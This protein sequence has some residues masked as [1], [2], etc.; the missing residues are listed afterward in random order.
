MEP[1]EKFWLQPPSSNTC[2]MQSR[3]EKKSLFANRDEPNDQQFL[4]QLIRD[5]VENFGK[6]SEEGFK[7]DPNE[8]SNEDSDQ[9]LDEAAHL[10]DLQ[11]D[12]KE[13]EALEKELRTNHFQNT[14]LQGMMD[15][16]TK[17][18]DVVTDEQIEIAEE[19]EDYVPTE[20]KYKRLNKRMVK[21]ER[22]IVDDPILESIDEDIKD[23][24]VG[25]ANSDELPL[26]DEAGE[27]PAPYRNRSTKQ[28]LSVLDQQMAELGLDDATDDSDASDFSDLDE[29][30][31]FEIAGVNIKE[32]MASEKLNPDAPSTNV[33]S[34]KQA[35][36]EK[37]DRLYRIP[38][39]RLLRED[40][41]VQNGESDEDYDDGDLVEIPQSNSESEDENPDSGDFFSDIPV[42]EETQHL[43][44][45]ETVVDDLKE[46]SVIDIESQKG[47]E[48]F[49]DKL[50][51]LRDKHKAWMKKGKKF[52]KETELMQLFQQY[53]S[54]KLKFKN[55]SP[56]E[57]QQL[58]DRFEEFSLNQGEG[59]GEGEFDQFSGELDQFQGEGEGEG[60]FEDEENS[61]SSSSSD[62]DAEI[63]LETDVGS[64][65]TNGTA[66]RSGSRSVSASTNG[67]ASPSGNGSTS[68]DASSSRS[69]SRST[70]HA[71]PAA[72]AIIKMVM[73]P[74]ESKVVDPPLNPDGPI[75]LPL[76]PSSHGHMEQ[77]VDYDGNDRIR[78]DRNVSATPKIRIV[79]MDDEQNYHGD[80]AQ[81]ADDV[82]HEKWENADDADVADE[83]DE[84][85]GFDMEEEELRFRGE[86][87]EEGYVMTPEEREQFL[88]DQA[89]VDEIN[90]KSAAFAN[91]PM[92]EKLTPEEWMRYEELNIRS[93]MERIIKAT[94]ATD[95]YGSNPENA[96]PHFWEMVKHK[97]V[98]MET[99]QREFVKYPKM[100]QR[101]SGVRKIDDLFKAGA[102]KLEGP[103]EQTVF[104]KESHE[105]TTLDFREHGGSYF[106]LGQN[107]DR[108][109]YFP[110]GLAGED[111]FLR[112]EFWPSDLRVHV[113]PLAS[114]IIRRID[115][116]EKKQ[117]PNTAIFGSRWTR[118]IWQIWNC[119]FN[120]GMGSSQRLHLHV[121]S[122]WE[123]MGFS[124]LW[125][126]R[127]Y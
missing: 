106:E 74:D 61:S 48:D 66:S 98:F 89:R 44:P 6:N 85:H 76:D 110:E 15:Q 38:R 31:D 93:Q 71:D 62:S 77:G 123:E 12:P 14:E 95:R 5:S 25:D 109:K 35:Y 59:E 72:D 122:R 9:D 50:E 82:A 20:K 70:H 19:M 16:M 92:W 27:L 51:D 18:I 73:H 124:L 94:R 17:R 114:D 81:Y 86:G 64:A 120:C 57:L 116:A 111:Y 2:W 88:K 28:I 99:L 121:G 80:I 104:P 23:D 34:I 112:D 107:T 101:A 58:K 108:L 33:P 43:L 36:V 8:D 37:F 127:N 1:P 65:S 84:V 126:W 41:P 105:V 115:D 102:L 47:L 68:S 21:L 119:Q 29:D 24:D 39:N 63:K 90:A 125:S 97:D 60:E 45:E 3:H 32:L 7:D 26:E 79:K 30:S 52:V 53:E 56:E 69:E 87:E 78:L 22:K 46:M 113:R 100:Q 83:P 117:F 42:T 103:Q 13:F 118:G 11:I 91:R 54:G 10:K 75:H 55:L 67:T 40:E 4:D 96:G 49:S